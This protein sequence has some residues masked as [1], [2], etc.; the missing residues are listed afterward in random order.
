MISLKITGIN[1]LIQSLAKTEWLDAKEVDAVVHS[2]TAPLVKAIK[3]GYS[4]HT[5]TGALANSVEAFKRTRKKGEPYFTYYVG[6]RYTSG[7]GL[8]IS[9]GGNAAH[10][11]EFGTVP[12]FRANHKLGGIGIVKNK[13]KTGL[14][15]VY[16]A[17]LSTGSIEPFGVIRKATDMVKPQCISMIKE[18]VL[19]LIRKEAK[20]QGLVA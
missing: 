5:K 10:L 15:K 19:G 3:A 9:Y 18:G 14:T 8:R 13:Q 11:L 7:S 1:E 17:T 20:K 2:A 16:G 6:P 4:V 12:R